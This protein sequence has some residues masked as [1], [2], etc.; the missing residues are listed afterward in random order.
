MSNRRYWVLRILLA[1]LV[2]VPIYFGLL[3][4]EE[5]WWLELAVVLVAAVFFTLLETP[6][7]KMRK[8]RPFR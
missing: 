2:A 3:W 5:K 7:S 8:R 6:L 4:A 1:M